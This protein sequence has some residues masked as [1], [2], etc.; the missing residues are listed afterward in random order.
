[1]IGPTEGGARIAFLYTTDSVLGSVPAPISPVNCQQELEMKLND[2]VALSAPVATLSGF[3]AAKQALGAV[4]LASGL[5]FASSAAHA[6]P[7]KHVTIQAY[8]VCDNA[9]SNCANTSYFDAFTAKIWDQADVVVNFLGM[10]Q[11]NDSNRLNETSFS[12]LGANADA[13]IVNLWFLNDLSDC[14]GNVGFG[15][16]YGCGTSGGWFALTK[17]VFSYSALGRIDTLSH[18]LGHVLGLGHDDFG[19]GGAD[20]LMT[21]GGSRSIAQALG[22]VNPDGLGLEKLTGA[23]ITQARTSRYLSDTGP[24]AVPEPGS[25]ALVAL[26]LLGLGAARR[27]SAA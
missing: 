19:A 3:R 21:S 16:L 7:T 20:N 4:V 5:L 24:T 15:S 26:A 25:L 14:G 1:L 18:E 17:Y 13:S 8:K 2:A 10:Q 12:D 22:D 23:Q 11:V 9:G 27:K 6:L